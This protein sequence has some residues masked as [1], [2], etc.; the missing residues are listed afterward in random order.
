MWIVIA[1]PIFI[2]VFAFSGWLASKAGES[3]DGSFHPY[4]KS[5]YISIGFLSALIL[6]FVIVLI[7]PDAHRNDDWGHAILL[8]GIVMVVPVALGLCLFSLKNLDTGFRSKIAAAAVGAF[9][10][11]APV[12]FIVPLCNIGYVLA[13]EYVGYKFQCRNAEVEVI[14]KVVQAVS[15]AI[16]PDSVLEPP[17]STRIAYHESLAI[18]LLNQGLVD[19]VERP[20]TDISGLKGVSKFERVKIKGEKR[21]ITDAKEHVH[22]Y[23]YE[24][25]DSISAEYVVIPTEIVE[26]DRGKKVLGEVKGVGGSKIEIY[27][28]VDKKLISRAQYYLSDTL[29][30]FCPSNGPSEFFTLSFVLDSL[31]ARNPKS[32]IP[33]L[34]L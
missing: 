34:S 27:R 9:W 5:R 7:A 11:T 26:R 15:V 33:S 18:R 25:I 2:A 3:A 1:L 13:S 6:T 29:R 32:Y 16:I 4:S 22:N 14:E 30:S 12:P 17:N 24:P 23:Q 8:F 10:A 20:A 31:S 19:Y 21:V 28:R